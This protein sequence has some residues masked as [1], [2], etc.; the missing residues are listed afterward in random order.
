[1]CGHAGRQA[2]RQWQC[3]YTTNATQSNYAMSS[4]AAKA[5]ANAKTD[6]PS[7]NVCQEHANATAPAAKGTEQSKTTTAT[8]GSGDA[9]AQSTGQDKTVGIRCCA[10]GECKQPSLQLSADAGRGHTCTHCKGRFHALCGVNGDMNDCGCRRHAELQQVQSALAMENDR[11]L[12]RFD[13]IFLRGQ[14]P[15]SLLQAATEVTVARWYGECHPG[16]LSTT[17]GLWFES[18]CPPL[19]DL[20]AMTW[21]HN[22][23]SMLETNRERKR[24]EDSGPRCDR[25]DKGMD[26]ATAGGLAKT[27]TPRRARARRLHIAAFAA[28]LVGDFSNAVGV[29][30][31]VLCLITPPPISNPPPCVTCSPV[32][33]GPPSCL[34]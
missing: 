13:I 28:R 17:R 29:C 32:T 12:D 27:S 14:W 19:P 23:S 2:G 15:L 8:M 9:A 4:N 26:K 7:Q 20:L 1:M 34:S 10:P 5:T 24:L 21:Q 11:M 18:K 30:C 6:Q 3:G 25:L 31:R 22:I 16:S 33:F